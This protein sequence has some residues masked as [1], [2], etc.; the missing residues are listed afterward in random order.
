MKHSPDR[1]ACLAALAAAALRAEDTSWMDLFARMAEALAN[2]TEGE[3]LAAFDPAMEGYG[4]LER[5]V[6]A[7]L[8]QNTVSSSVE[9][10]SHRA[11]GDAVRVELDW[12]LEIRGRQPAGATVRRRER[13]LC[14]LERRQRGWRITSFT[15]LALFDPPPP[16]RP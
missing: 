7:L 1:R 3:F 12:F 14:R 11:E 9:R 5:Q 10:L 15:P 2:D 4:A 8:A 13:A 6:R 16:A